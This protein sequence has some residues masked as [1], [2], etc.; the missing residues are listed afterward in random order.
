MK[1]LS[2]LTFFAVRFLIDLG[3]QYI[4]KSLTKRVKRQSI[5]FLCRYQSSIPPPGPF[6]VIFKTQYCILSSF[7][8]LQPLQTVHLIHIETQNWIV[9]LFSLTNS[10]KQLFIGQVRPFTC[11]CRSCLSSILCSSND[12]IHI[13]TGLYVRVGYL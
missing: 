2:S 7:K 4:L 13:F 10:R 8:M 6:S 1:E 9:P 3:L 12:P 5:Y 11:R